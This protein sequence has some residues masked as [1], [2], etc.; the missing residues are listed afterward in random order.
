MAK[1][2]RAISW[3]YRS[4]IEGLV[5][6]VESGELSPIVRFV[7]FDRAF[8]C[9]CR[10]LRLEVR[11]IPDFVQMM[12]RFE[13][14]DSEDFMV[15]VSYENWRGLLESFVGWLRAPT[16]PLVL[17]S[18]ET[19]VCYYDGTRFLVIR[20]TTRGYRCYAYDYLYN[21]PADT[22][23]ENLETAQRVVA[24]FMRA[25]RDLHLQNA[26]GSRPQY[27]PCRCRGPRWLES[28]VRCVRTA[29]SFGSWRR[30]RSA[31]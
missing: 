20:A 8:L 6:L 27:P 31:D 5:Q 24:M 2:S 17:W 28:L 3:D 23:L 19:P 11:Y 14:K 30:T 18:G 25:R 29:F 4:E 13:H 12:I 7:P 15:L 22:I 21:R 26:A 10:D 9:F 16:A 1:R